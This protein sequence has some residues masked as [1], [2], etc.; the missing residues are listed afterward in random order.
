VAAPYYELIEIDTYADGDFEQ[1]TNDRHVTDMVWDEATKTLTIKRNDNL[2][3]LTEVLSGIDGDTG[4]QGIQGV[5]GPAGIGI[6]LLGYKALIS[7]LPTSGN[8]LG[9][10][11][12]V[13]EDGHLWSWDGAQWF[14]VGHLDGV[15][16]IQGIQGVKGDQGPAGT[17]GEDGING[18]NGTDGID[19]ENGASAYQLWIAEGNTGT[20]QEF[21]DS[22]KGVDGTDGI[23]GTD[24]DSAYV[25]IYFASNTAGAGFS[26]IPSASLQ[27]I[28]IKRTTTE[29]TTPIVSDFAGLWVKYL[30]TNG[31]QGIQ[32]IPG[33]TG[34]NGSDGDDGVTPHIGPNGNWYIG[35][36]DT[37][38]KAEGT[39]GADGEKG[40]KGDKG[41]PGIQ[42]PAG[43]DGVDANTDDW[44]EWDYRDIVAGTAADYDLDLKALVPYTIDSAVMRVD[45]GTLTV[46]IKI[47]ST[48]VTGLSAVA[49][50]TDIDETA[51]TGANTVAAG[52]KVMLSV[53]STYTGA[54][55]MIRGKINITRT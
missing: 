20:V 36:T 7:D 46:A 31:E 30:G 48:A 18:T 19:G 51:A 14:D 9:D 37:G 27:Y 52:D 16:G 45:T 26:A 15:Q 49:V 10:S 53:S 54:P 50:D 42:G 35:E 43:A 11:W 25:Y 34:A 24:G 6:Q 44:I 47:G 22:L 8:T 17:D 28:A 21:L 4:P 55:T 13:E 29:I 38:V 32:G 3:D 23:D 1:E 12:H 39:D 2:P 33:T 40:D 5:Q 41:D